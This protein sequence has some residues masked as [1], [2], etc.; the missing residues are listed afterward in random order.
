MRDPKRIPIICEKLETLWKTYPDMRLGQLMVCLLGTDP[1]YM[2]DGIAEK[3]L[4]EWLE[5][6]K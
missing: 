4:D 5:K 1:F 3:K 2:E 6:F